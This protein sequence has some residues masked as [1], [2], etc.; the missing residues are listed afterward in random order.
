[1]IGR[2]FEMAAMKILLIVTLISYGSAQKSKFVAAM[3]GGKGYGK[4]SG[5]IFFEKKGEAVKNPDSSSMEKSKDS[6]KNVEVGLH[7]HQYGEYEVVY[8]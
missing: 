1:M 8:I 6:K 3:I 4:L 2:H 5:Q 7:I